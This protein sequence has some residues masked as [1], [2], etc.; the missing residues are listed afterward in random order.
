MI[1]FVAPADGGA[2]TGSVSGSASA[3]AQ[4]TALVEAADAAARAG[5]AGRGRRRAGHRRPPRPTGTTPPARPTSTSTTRSPRRSARRSAGPSAG[6]RVLYGFVNHERHHDLPRLLHRAAPAARPA[7]RPL[8]L[9]RQD[10]RPDPQ[11]LG[12]RR[13]PRLRR[14]ST[15]SRWTRR[16]SSGSAG[17]HAQVDLPAGRYDTILPPIGGGRPDD[18]RLLVRRRPRRPR[19]AVGLQQARRRH[20]DRR[21][22]RPARACTCSP[23]RPTPASG[24]RRS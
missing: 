21:A 7:D 20:P 4:V 18:R 22:D 15:P 3:T 5:S 6:G 23:T 19:G 14:T 2:A 8:R 1:S 17:A 24:A 10:G 11:R 16:S 13:H 9:H 12:R